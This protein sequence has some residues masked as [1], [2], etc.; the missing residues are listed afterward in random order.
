MAIDSKIKR[1]QADKIRRAFSDRIADLGF[2]HTK[3]SFWTRPRGHVIQFIHLHLFRSGPHFRV[4]F[5]IRVLNDD[6]DHVVLNGPTSDEYRGPQYRYHLSFHA[7][8]NTLPRCIDDLD[9]F[10]RDFGE[11]WFVRFSG[12]GALLGPSSPLGETAM[13][14]LRAA[15]VGDSD[16]SRVA[17]SRALLGVA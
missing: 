14:C 6:D 10:C 16:P 3:T 15:I 5:G 8:A 7:R 2:A 12:A 9:R 1:S 13:Q 11:P 4:H 17:A